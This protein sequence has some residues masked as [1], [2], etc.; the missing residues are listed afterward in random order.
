MTPEDVIAHLSALPDVVTQT[1]GPGDGSPEIAWGDSFVYLS[2]GGGIPANTQP[3]ATIVTK[4]YPGD[5]GS[6][7]DRP[8]AFRV[9]IA[10]GRS[11]TERYRGAEDSD[12]AERDVVHI[13][14]VYGQLGWVAVIEPAE[15]TAAEVRELLTLAHGLAQA[16][17]ARR[18]GTAD[19]G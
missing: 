6:Q 8:G 12:P 13:H 18:Q 9:N 11:R 4:D 10:V 17:S 1:V 2:P 15:R 3:F 7:L 16:R 19:P 14:P 5:E